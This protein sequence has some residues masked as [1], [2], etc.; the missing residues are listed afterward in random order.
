MVTGLG[1]TRFS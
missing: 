1:Q